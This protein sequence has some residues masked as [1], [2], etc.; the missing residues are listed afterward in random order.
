METAKDKILYI[1]DRLGLPGIKAAQAMNMS[2]ASFRK[3]KTESVFTHQFN[4]K[5]YNDL[6]TFLKCELKEIINMS[7]STEKAQNVY[8]TIIDKVITMCQGKSYLV[9][10]EGWNLFDELKSI[11]DSLETLPVFENKDSY[12]SV[13]AL[14][15]SSTNDD[16]DFNSLYTDYVHKDK[17]NPHSRWFDLIIY[18]RIKTIN[19]IINS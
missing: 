3:K 4:D 13:I 6:I 17:E 12:N 7:E 2:E 1:L 11:V 8:E 16:F 10:Q 5:N 19:S 14:I 9:A 15:E 18:R